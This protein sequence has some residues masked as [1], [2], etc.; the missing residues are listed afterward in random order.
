MKRI[1]TSEIYS[2]KQK[3]VKPVK[4][5]QLEYERLYLKNVMRKHHLKGKDIIIKQIY[6]IF[7]LC[8][9]LK[10]N[11]I[12]CNQD[13]ALLIARYIIEDDGLESVGIDMVTTQKSTILI[14]RLEHLANGYEI[15]EEE[16]ENRLEREWRNIVM[17]KVQEYGRK[18]N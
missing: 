9:A 17:P 1:R 3:L 2:E 13:S 15:Y 12:K 16:E 8:E 10:S 18:I 7:E 4:I 5:T 6:S 14:S 11:P